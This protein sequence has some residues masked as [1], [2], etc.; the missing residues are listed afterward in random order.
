MRQKILFSLF[1]SA[2]TI[3][4]LL[5]VY[6]NKEELNQ[7]GSSDINQAEYLEY[8]ASVTDENYNNSVYKKNYTQSKSLP[9][10]G[11]LDN[12]TFFNTQAVLVKKKSIK[13]TP[14]FSF[15]YSGITMENSS[16]ELSSGGT[17]LLADA[18][19]ILFSK[20]GSTTSNQGGG[21]SSELH[22]LIST[23][24][25]HMLPIV[26]KL[27]DNQSQGAVDP[28]GNLDDNFP[29]MLPV[30]NGLPFLLF[31]ACAY[32]IIRA[33]PAWNKNKKEVI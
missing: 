29:P 3:L 4:L 11:S 17:A 14:D 1:I 20:R 31:L 21:V 30:S 32:L 5:L 33:I 10:T 28:G 23:R 27:D 26:I 12:N 16:Q 6:L 24:A 15:D 19:S 9:E 25:A 7:T 18:S 13:Q 22:G 8:L 2:S